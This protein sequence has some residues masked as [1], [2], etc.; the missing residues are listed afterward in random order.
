MTTNMTNINQ[1]IIP[2]TNFNNNL[3]SS[4]INV[5]ELIMKPVD[6]KKIINDIKNSNSVS[7]NRI[8]EET[9]HDDYHTKIMT[10]F[11]IETNTF[12]GDEYHLPS[13]E[14]KEDPLKPTNQDKEQKKTNGDI[15]SNGLGG[16]MDQLDISNMNFNPYNSQNLNNSHY[17]FNNVSRISRHYSQLNLEEVWDNSVID[18]SFGFDLK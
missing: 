11:K 10:T 4:T 8:R 1:T 7:G 13:S 6:K 14:I 16:G 17:N 18:E 2:S 15:A 5:S 3:N 12:L 9:V